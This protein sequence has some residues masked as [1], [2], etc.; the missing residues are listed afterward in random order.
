MTGH[1]RVNLA[2][3]L[4]N[5]DDSLCVH[6]PALLDNVTDTVFAFL[7]IQRDREDIQSIFTCSETQ[8]PKEYWSLE[9]CVENLKISS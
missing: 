2:W 6:V 5:E 1:A 7:Q 3:K 4:N 8:N 9:E